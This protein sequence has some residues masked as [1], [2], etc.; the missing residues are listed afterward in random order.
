M[1]WPRQLE[2]VDHFGLGGTHRADKHLK[3]ARSRNQAE[4]WPR[5]SAPKSDITAKANPD[6]YTLLWSSVTTHGVGPVL[7][8][9]LP[10]DAVRD[11][12][13][14]GLAASL[15]M[16]AAV[17]KPLLPPLLLSLSSFT[18]ARAVVTP[19]SAV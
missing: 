2:K 8:S 14:I 9:K 16:I 11:F 5:T 10:Y 7:Y 6:G 19:G 13:H 18:G 3:D 1:F 15:P 17:L 4:N 12:T